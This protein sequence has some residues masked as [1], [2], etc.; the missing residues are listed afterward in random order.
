M[1]LCREKKGLQIK[2][3][4]SVKKMDGGKHHD[5]SSYQK[6]KTYTQVTYSWLPTPN[7]SGIS[8]RSTTLLKTEH[9]SKDSKDIMPLCLPTASEPCRMSNLK[10]D[11]TQNGILLY[12]LLE[13]KTGTFYLKLHFKY[14]NMI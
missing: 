13:G 2:Q 3:I 8:A 14:I 10:A 11:L 7:V 4:I 12:N 6:H 1:F 9:R 5:I